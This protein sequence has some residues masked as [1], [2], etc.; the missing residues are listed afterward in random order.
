MSSSLSGV[1]VRSYSLL[2]STSHSGLQRVGGTT[3]E[4]VY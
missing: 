3:A 4:K 2:V 1:E